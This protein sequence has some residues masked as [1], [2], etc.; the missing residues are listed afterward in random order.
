MKNFVSV[1]WLY[2]NID[3]EDLLVFDVRSDLFD[4]EYGKRVFETGHIKNAVFVDL[5]KFLSGPKGKHGGRH[6]LPNPEE[7]AETIKNFGI[8]RETLVVAY[9]EQKIASSARFCFMLRL[10]GHEKNFILDGGIKRWIEKGYPLEKGS[11]PLS[12]FD[13]KV[14]HE[15]PSDFPLDFRRDL[16]A[17]VNDVR[18]AIGKEDTVIIDSRMP[19]RYKGL[20]EPVDFKKGHIP[21][22]VN[23]YWKENLKE[24]GELKDLKELKEKFMSLKEKK[25]IIVYC[26]SGIDATFNFFVLDELGIKA[27]VYLGSFSDWITYEENEIWTDRV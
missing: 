10:L 6:P 1:D 2:E 26:G 19:D 4:K 5:E 9:D 3:K 17:D 25:D 20:I 15:N 8:T 18:A 27:K 7:F 16:I 21:G 12:D 11:K 13:I 14:S 22:A 23:Y 24:N